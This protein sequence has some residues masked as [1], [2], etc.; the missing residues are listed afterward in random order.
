[1]HLPL[2]ELKETD[3]GWL[4]IPSLILN[5][6]TNNSHSLISAQNNTITKHLSFIFILTM[7][8]VTI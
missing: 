3:Q 7:W 5:Q 1:M 4:I 6:I 2:L 8:L